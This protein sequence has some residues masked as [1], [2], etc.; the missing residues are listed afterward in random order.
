LRARIVRAPTPPG[1]FELVF[2]QAGGGRD[3]RYDQIDLTGDTLDLTFRVPPTAPGVAQDLYLW[4]VAKAP[5]R[6]EDPLLLRRRW[7][8]RDT[9]L[10][11][12]A[13][14]GGSAAGGPR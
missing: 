14:P 12:P 3:L 1:T 10:A 5:F 13:I 8:Q 4:N 11:A 2:K 7:S 9:V 6:L